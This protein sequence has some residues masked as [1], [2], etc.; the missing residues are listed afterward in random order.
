LAHS[1][2]ICFYKHEILPPYKAA[3]ETWRKKN[4]VDVSQ[5]TELNAAADESLTAFYKEEFNL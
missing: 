4:K 1:N 5:L 3:L 2:A